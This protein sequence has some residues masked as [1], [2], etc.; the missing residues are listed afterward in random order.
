M[1]PDIIQVVEGG[2]AQTQELLRERFD[3]IFYTGGTNVGRI[4]ASAA[5]NHLTPCT[6]ELGGKCPLYLDE[7]VNM[8]VAAKRCL[9]YLL[10]SNHI[11]FFSYRRLILSQAGMGQ[12]HQ[13]GPNLCCTRLRSLQPESGRKALDSHQKNIAKFLRA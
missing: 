11:Y 10:L 5:A 4:I 12:V 2:V 9:H 6:L 3:H 1:D 13:S 8:D 7:D